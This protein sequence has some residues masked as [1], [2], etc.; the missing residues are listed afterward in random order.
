MD[1]YATPRCLW[2][3]A[4]ASRY[5][6]LRLTKTSLNQSAIS[7]FATASL[8]RYYETQ[9]SVHPLIFLLRCL[10]SRQQCLLRSLTYISRVGRRPQPPGILAWVHV[11]IPSP[12]NCLLRDHWSNDCTSPYAINLSRRVSITIPSCW[13]SLQSQLLGASLSP[14]YRKFIVIVC[15]STLLCII[16]IVT[17]AFVGYTGADDEILKLDPWM[18]VRI[19]PYPK[20]PSP[21]K[22]FSSSSSWLVQAVYLS[23]W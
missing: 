11:R 12:F 10:V 23:C 9:Q 1:L 14:V 7:N 15:R 17:F 2:V 5:L 18:K 13:H 19:M 16:A 8:R 21:F 6:A 20:L 3:R 4:Q 22:S